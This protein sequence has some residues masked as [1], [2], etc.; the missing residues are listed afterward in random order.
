L[1]IG[2]CFDVKTVTHPKFAASLRAIDVL[3]FPELV[4]GGYAALSKGAT[5]HRPDD[6]LFGTFREVS[7]RFSLYCVAGTTYL[8][9][10]DSR[11]TNTSLV[12]HRGRLVHR[13]DKIHLF[14]PTNDHKYFSKGVLIS[15]FLIGVSKRKIRAGIAVCYDLR[16]PELMR[17]MAKQ[18]MELLFVPARWPA[19]RE[20]AWIALL[21]ARAIENQIFAVG[22]NARGKE[23]GNSYAFDPLGDMIFSSKGKTRSNLHTFRIDPHGL[24]VAKKLHHNLKDAVLL[25]KAALLRLPPLQQH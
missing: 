13:Y 20:E 3:V 14:K 1:Q 5:P 25:K 8:L 22:C 15:T 9:H 12:F 17:A 4:D 10:S 11:K 24:S 18:G 16:F 7:K 19:A 23:G 6:P 2:L 21:K